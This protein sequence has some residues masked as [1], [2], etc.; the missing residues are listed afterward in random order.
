MKMRT[1]PVSTKK[2]S[3]W[4]PIRQIYLLLFFL[5]YNAPPPP[6]FILF[7]PFSCMVCFEN[8]P[9]PFEKKTNPGEGLMD[10]GY[11]KR[12]DGRILHTLEDLRYSGFPRLVRQPKHRQHK[13]KLTTHNTGP[14]KL[15]GDPTNRPSNNH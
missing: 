6:P 11:G 4:R 3:R 12:C 15:I 13:I 14:V 9:L 5:F 1:P 8:T 10:N 7:R 2:K